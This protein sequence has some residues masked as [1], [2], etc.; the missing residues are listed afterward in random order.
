MTIE[1]PLCATCKYAISDENGIPIKCKAFPDGI[2]EKIFTSVD[3]HFPTSG[4]HGI[5][6]KRKT[7]DDY[8]SKK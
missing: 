3:H 7:R 6:Y 4:D 1:E 8:F 5:Q 2:P